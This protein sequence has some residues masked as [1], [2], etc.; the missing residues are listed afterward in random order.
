MVRLVGADTSASMNVAANFSREICD[1]GAVEQPMDDAG[2]LR[3][4]LTEP[5]AFA[6]LY[7]RHGP[8]IQRYV[9]RR[10]GMVAVEDLAAEVFVRAFRDRARCRLAHDSALPWLFGVANHVIADHRRVEKRRLTALERLAHD[11]RN[12]VEHPDHELAPA[13]AHALREMPSAD[14]DA[15]LLVAWGELSYEETAAALDVP[16]GTVRSRIFRARQRLTSALGDRAALTALEYRLPGE[17]D[18]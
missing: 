15:L 3:R 17:A 2:L 7:D 8:T 16:V 1:I 11:R 13:L 9:A 6:G 12:A 14:R 4:S 18:V 5:A 10:V